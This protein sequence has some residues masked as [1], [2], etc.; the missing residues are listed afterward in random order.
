MS[1]SRFHIQFISYSLAWTFLD[2]VSGY[3]S[4]IFFEFSKKTVEIMFNLDILVNG[5]VFSE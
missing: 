5:L 2:D 1:P 3:N 4:I